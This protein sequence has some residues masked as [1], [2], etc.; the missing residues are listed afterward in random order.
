M[1][2]CVCVCV[3]HQLWNA[4]ACDS[5]ARISQLY[6]RIVR[7]SVLFFLPSGRPGKPTVWLAETFGVMGGVQTMEI[8]TTA[9]TPAPSKYFQFAHEG[10]QFFVLYELFQGASPQ[11]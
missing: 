1:C 2:V 10:V 7:R 3:C 4:H 6:R 5:Q 11:L 8:D 9:L